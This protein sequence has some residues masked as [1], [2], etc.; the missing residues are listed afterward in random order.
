M[1]IRGELKITT[2]VMAHPKRFAHASKLVASNPELGA[3][4]VVDP[5]PTGPPSSTRTG[6]LAFAAT[7]DTATHLLLLE[8]DVELCHGFYEHLL[9]VVGAQPRA[10]ISLHAACTSRTS[11]AV[12][13]AAMHGR[14]WAQ[15]LGH[16]VPTVAIVM[17]AETASSFAAYLKINADLKDHNDELLRLFLGPARVLVTV[18]NLVEHLPFPSVEGNVTPDGRRSVIYLPDGVDANWNLPM[19]PLDMVPYLTPNLPRKAVVAVNSQGVMAAQR[20]ALAML[21]QCGFSEAE[22]ERNYSTDLSRSQVD[23][24]FGVLSYQLWLVAA[25]LG[26]AFMR[27]RSGLAGR[28]GPLFDATLSSW[29]EGLMVGAHQTDVNAAAALKMFLRRAVQSTLGFVDEE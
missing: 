21:A 26:A 24:M 5:D 14:P 19:A 6:K 17:P 29:V 22:V 3:L 18:P 27:D 9:A 2:V 12:R 10:V 4:L 23:S 15:V 20:P 8:D 7:E 25:S 1:L 13:L 16:Y 28:P 11:F